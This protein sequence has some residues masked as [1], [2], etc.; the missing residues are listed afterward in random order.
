MNQADLLK[1]LIEVLEKS[2]IPYLLVGSFASSA[3][4]E[5]R[6]TLDI[7]VVIDISDDQIPPLCEAFP[8]PDYYVSLEAAQEAVRQRRQF[9]VIHPASGN[10]IDFMIARKDEWGESQLARRQLVQV[11]PD[12][13]GYVACPEDVILGKLLYYQEGGS[14]KHL[15][16][17]AGIMRISP[18]LVDIEYLSKWTEKLGLSNVWEAVLSRLKNE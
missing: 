17:I 10:K 16:D 1:R 15:R 4:G 13:A 14:E 12:R 11:L 7:D 2:G 8:F 5:P 18:S 6:L 9:N 3:Y